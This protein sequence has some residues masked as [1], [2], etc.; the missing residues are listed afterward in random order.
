MSKNGV[1]RA[2]ALTGVGFAVLLVIFR[3]IE[4]GASLPDANDSTAKVVAFW[5][6]HDSEQIAV[7]I[8]ASFAAV[9]FVWF[10][11]VLRSALA[12]SEG[13]R[14]TF[15]NLSLAGGVL[16]GAG[17]LFITTVEYAAAD[18]AGEVPAAVTQTLS[19][20]QADTF[21]M[22]AA[23]FAIFGLAAGLVILRTAVFPGW[24]GWISVVAGVLW[25]TPVQF[26]GIV[27]SVA[28]VVATSI[29]LFR[30]A[31]ESSTVAARPLEPP[32]PA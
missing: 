9:L 18:S 25:L 21:F 12:D 20:L 2:S 14:A 10:S 6:K 7:A 23:G 4:S 5:T 26:A 1:S 31:G 16:A 27:L 28:F 19:V 24:L 8:I 17:M 29:M 13:G 3:V 32:A 30:D 11:G 15:A 22:V